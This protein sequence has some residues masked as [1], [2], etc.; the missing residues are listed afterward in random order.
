MKIVMK[1]F[2]GIELGHY[3]VKLAYLEQGSLKT[4]I[5]ERIDIDFYTNNHLYAKRIRELL[6]A[7]EIRCKHTVFVLPPE[8][9]Y[10][11]RV[12]LPLLTTEQ[13]K[14]N[15]PYEFV[16]YIGEQTELYQFDYAVL[17]RSSNQLDLL[18]AACKKELCTELQSFAK[19]A[20]LKLTGLVPSVIGLERLLNRNNDQ[21]QDFVI[22]DL[23]F[24]ALRIH[25]FRQGIY[26]TT[27]LLEPGCEEIEQLYQSEK[28]SADQ[29]SQCCQTV[30]IQIMRVLN[31]YS[32]NHMDN[33]LDTLY[34]CGGGAR[35]QKLLAAI[36]R[37]VEI[38]VRSLAVLFPK[39]GLKEMG[40]TAE[41]LDSPQTIGV[42]LT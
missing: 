30:A 23:G 15:L 16:D 32:F 24:R 14:L 36:E 41:C 26:D 12:R 33:T 27:R 18:A 20:G 10:V 17:E 6:T 5:S 13:L 35:E 39:L 28:E 38:P 19:L 25:F 22:V 34:Y 40:I 3:R 11:K 9:T 8:K 29:I 31:F 1:R 2:L 37:A 7:H 42:L 4:Y 21:K